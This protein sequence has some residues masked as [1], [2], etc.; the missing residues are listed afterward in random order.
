[1]PFYLH[2][3][4]ASQQH[5]HNLHAKCWSWDARQCKPSLH[6]SMS[7]SRSRHRSFLQGT[8]AAHRGFLWRARAADAGRYLREAQRAG[9]RLV[10]CGE[11]AT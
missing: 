2:A 3:S 9:L 8:P 11:P 7:S 10:F 5:V 4:L 6:S 1:M